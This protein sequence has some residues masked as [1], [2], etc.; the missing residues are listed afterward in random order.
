MRIIFTKCF[1]FIFTFSCFFSAS[2]MSNKKSTSAFKYNE[3]LLNKTLIKDEG[4]FITCLSCTCFTR[5]LKNIY[6]KDSSF[7]LKYPFFIIKDCNPDFNNHEK[8]MTTIRQSYSD[9]ISEEIYNV[10]LVKK[11]QNEYTFRILKV[12]ESDNLKKIIVS[13]FNEK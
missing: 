12:E 5:E 8:F 13:F 10:T 1:I 9:S 6:L 4:V 7:F 2:C 11:I 3:P